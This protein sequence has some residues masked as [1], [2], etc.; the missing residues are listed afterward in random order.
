MG[1]YI[2]TKSAVN[3]FLKEK[4]LAVIGASRDEKKFGSAAMK[5]LLE[6]GYQVY[7]VHPQARELQ[8]QACYSS[9][10][11]LPERIQACLLVVP[12]PETEKLIPQLAEKGIRKIWM[13]QGAGSDEAIQLSQERGMETVARECIFMFAAPVTGGHAFHHWLWKVFGKLPKD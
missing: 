10:A 12:P 7:P 6:K 13:Q 3:S 9:V 1:D 11:E 8:G 4:E 5:M 2:T